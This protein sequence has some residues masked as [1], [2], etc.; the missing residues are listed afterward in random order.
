VV[1]RDGKKLVFRVKDGKAEAVPVS[2]SRNLGD[3][4]EVAPGA[5]KAGDR[6]VL[7]PTDKVVDGAKLTVAGK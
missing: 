4:L 2:P 1:E 3:L 6:L 7:A 5:L